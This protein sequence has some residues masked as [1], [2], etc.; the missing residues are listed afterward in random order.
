MTDPMV[1]WAKMAPEYPRLAKVAKK[2]LTASATSIRTETTWSHAG[3]INSRK[4]MTLHTKTL[5]RL[6][7]LQQNCKKTDILSLTPEDYIRQSRIARHYRSIRVAHN[8]LVANPQPGGGVAQEQ[9][10]PVPE[11]MDVDAPNENEWCAAGTALHE[12][13]VF[14]N[15]T[16][17]VDDSVEEVWAAEVVGSFQQYLDDLQRGAGNRT[18]AELQAM[19]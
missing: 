6:L 9:R 3:A 10:A 12:D 8:A 17:L 2:L 5:D 13:E 16:V 18:R 7:F 4:R 11:Q 19:G 1:A 15:D 14:G